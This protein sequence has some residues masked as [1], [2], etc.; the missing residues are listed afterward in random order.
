LTIAEAKA[1]SELWY[2]TCEGKQM[3]PVTTSELKQLGSS[4]Y[5]RGA[6]MVWQEG[7]PAWVRAESI[8]GL[9]PPTAAL[10]AAPAPREPAGIAAAQREPSLES[11]AIEPQVQ[12]RRRVVVDD[13]FDDDEFDRPIRRRREPAKGL[14][15]LALGLIIGGVGLVVLVSLGAI[16]FVSAARR[17]ANRPPAFAARPKFNVPPPNAPGRR[18]GKQPFNA[19]GAIIGPVNVEVV[20][21]VGANAKWEKEFT[22][23]V[24]KKI[25]VKVNSD[26][27]KNDIDLYIYDE[28]GEEVAADDLPF[29]ICE[30]EFF[31][32]AK[33][34]YRFEIRNLGDSPSNCTLTYTQP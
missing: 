6:D 22:F 12:R 30:T 19:N 7:M 2:F 14:S 24:A 29:H 31:A 3:E 34:K 17:P 9:I 1:M 11:A 4:G 18:I 28:N 26:I 15:G 20:G 32:E 5:L 27:L 33:H 21:V 25:Q 10:S 8:P 13:D 23:P 16:V